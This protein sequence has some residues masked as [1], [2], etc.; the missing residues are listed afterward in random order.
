VWSAA[1]CCR[2]GDIAQANACSVIYDPVSLA[3]A[4]LTAEPQNDECRMQKCPDFCGSFFK[5]GPSAD[6]RMSGIWLLDEGGDIFFLLCPDLEEV[7]PEFAAD[8]DA[9]LLCVVGDPVQHIFF[10]GSHIVGENSLEIQIGLHP[11]GDGI[12]A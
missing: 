7:W 5:R 12:N 1:A 6:I 9:F 3:R 2:F 10:A 11:S 4:R 8:K